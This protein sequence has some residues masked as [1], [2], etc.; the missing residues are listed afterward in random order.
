MGL[1][2]WLDIGWFGPL[3]IIG[4]GLFVIYR[5]RVDNGRDG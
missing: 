2:G 3:L 5:R 4:I 1:L